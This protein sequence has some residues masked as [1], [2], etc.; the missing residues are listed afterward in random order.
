VKENAL[1]IIARSKNA[2]YS[3]LCSAVDKQKYIQYMIKEV[4][5]DDSKS[6]IY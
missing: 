1:K 5:V 2:C 6:R 4:A 3:I